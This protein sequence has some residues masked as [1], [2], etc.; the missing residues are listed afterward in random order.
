MYVTVPMPPKPPGCTCRDDWWNEYNPDCPWHGGV[1]TVSCG[2]SPKSANITINVDYRPRPK[3]LR[4]DE[5]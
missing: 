1:T 4:P 5:V 3:A 2:C